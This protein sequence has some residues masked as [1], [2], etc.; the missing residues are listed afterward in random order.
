[1]AVFTMITTTFAMDSFDVAMEKANNGDPKAETDI[2][3]MYFYGLGCQQ[4]MEQALIWYHKAAAQGYAEAKDWIE[5]QAS[6]ENEF[7]F[8]QTKLKAEQGDLNAECELGNMYF[9]GIGCTKSLTDASKWYGKAAVRGSTEAKK[10]ISEIQAQADDK[11]KAVIDT[12]IKSETEAKNLADA[13]AAAQLKAESEAAA[14]AKI[15]AEQKAKEQ[16]K[17]KIGFYGC[18][19]FII[20]IM[21]FFIRKL[22]RTKTNLKKGTVGWVD[23]MALFLGTFFILFGSTI[24]EIAKGIHLPSGKGSSS[25]SSSSQGESAES[26]VR[27]AVERGAGVAGSASV[28]CSP[29]GGEFFGRFE[30]RD[31]DQYQ[32]FSG[33]VSGKPGRWNMDSF[34]MGNPIQK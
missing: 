8:G 11:L 22:Q 20:S 23:G 26:F 28:S 27:R 9:N 24:F 18:G 14:Q 17:Q 15:E 16:L 33:R 5:Q 2:G 29:G 31:V 10:A 13:K 25:S 32:T 4:N 12:Y 3:Y 7:K 6:K 19:V 21:W 1:M 34:Q 30:W